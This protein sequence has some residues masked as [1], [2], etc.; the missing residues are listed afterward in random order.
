ML[1]IIQLLAFTSAVSALG[2]NCRGSGLCPRASWNNDAPVSVMQLLRDA[3][4]AAPNPLST[5]YK[6]GDHV[7]CV[8]QSQKITI[9]VG[10]T[11]DGFKGSVGLSGSIKEGGICL[12]PQYMASGA[13]LT[14]AQIRPL[15]DALLEHR[16]STCGSVPIHFVDEGSNDPS[17]GILTFNYVAAPYCVGNCIS[18]VGG[19]SSSA[20]AG[21]PTTVTETI[22][23]LSSTV[24]DSSM[25]LSSTLDTVPTATETVEVVTVTA[26][27]PAQ[28]G[29]NT[30]AQI[31][32]ASATP[33]STSGVASKPRPNIGVVVAF[34]AY[35]I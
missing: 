12:F 6:S 19:S 22:V 30:Q 20:D 14:L 2:I 17:D 25:Q 5:G 24:E 3:V 35:W 4:Y 18:A 15:M 29:T 10:F 11:L 26:S 9:D 13:T 16:C 34:M 32:V 31:I 27:D 23:A 33:S 21:T 7:I 28:T 8:S 1:S